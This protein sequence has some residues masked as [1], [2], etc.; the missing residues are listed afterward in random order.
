MKY[1]IKNGK[2]I[3]EG[4]IQEADI[5]I[6]ENIIQRIEK[7]ISDADAVVIDAQN[8]YIIPG[9]IDDQVHFREPA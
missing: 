8:Q 4:K 6:H 1:L 5:L 3:N 7:D 2:I 9:I